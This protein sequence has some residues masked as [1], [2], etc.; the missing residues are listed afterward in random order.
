MKAYRGVDIQIHIFLTSALAGV[1]GQ[2]HAP[3]AL[4]PGER[5]P[6]N[7]WIGGSVDHRV[8]LD[9]VEKRKFLT[10]TGLKLQPLGHPA[11]SQS[12]Y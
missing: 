9:Y 6:G 2:H 4:P 12:L 7:H 8:G 3:A 10:L 1:S 5:S 11:R